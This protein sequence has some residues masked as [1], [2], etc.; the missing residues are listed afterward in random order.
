MLEPFLN[1]RQENFFAI[2]TNDL[3]RIPESIAAHL[4]KIGDYGEYHL[5]VTAK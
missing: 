2:T 1:D 4:M 3:A 5:L